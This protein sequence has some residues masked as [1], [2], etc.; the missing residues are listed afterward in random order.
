MTYNNQVNFIWLIEILL[1][2][3]K[4]MFQQIHSSDSIKY[5]ILKKRKLI[6][7]DNE[8]IKRWLLIYQLDQSIPTMSDTLNHSATYIFKQ[9][10]SIQEELPN[11]FAK[12]NPH[13]DMYI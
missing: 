2:F 7:A 12:Q 13:N 1:D 3:L 11:I 8:A 6:S 9:F 4:T 10:Q 5:I